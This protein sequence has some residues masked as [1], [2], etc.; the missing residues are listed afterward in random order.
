MPT[1]N[2][3]LFGIG[4]GSAQV[5]DTNGLLGQYQNMLAK[6]EQ[7]R[8]YE[9]KQLTDAQ[10]QLKPEG[11]RNDADRKDFFNQVDKWRNQAISA[12]QERDPYKKSLL[13]SQAQ[14]AYMQAQALADQSKK[15][16]VMENAFSTQLLNPAIRDRYNDDVVDRVL[17]NRELGVNDPTHIK[18]FNSLEQQADHNKFL[19]ANEEADKVL[20]DKAKFDQQL[21]KNKIGTSIQYFRKVPDDVRVET[22]KN[23]AKVDRNYKKSLMDI[24]PDIF[25]NPEMSY[26]QKIDEAVKRVVKT[27]GALTEY[28]TPQQKVDPQPDRFYEHYNYALAHPKGDQSAVIA[29]TPSNVTLPYNEGKAHVNASGYVPLSIPNKN[30]G[31]SAAYDLSSGKPVAQLQSSGDYSVVGVGNF[32]FIKKGN[33]KGA[34]A[35][36][37]FAENNPNAIQDK[38]MVH[39]QSTDKYGTTDYLISY[40]KLPANIKNSKSIREAL[41]NFVPASAQQPQSV[42]GKAKEL[43]KKAVSPKAPEKITYQGKTYGKDDIEQAAKASGMSVSEYLK[44][45]GQ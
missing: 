33:K 5:L 21:I 43:I 23:I 34:I 12:T 11:L 27:T 25:A 15:A 14:Q 10:A 20:I 30:F 38:P 35:Q 9:L 24:Y 32:P 44:E 31:G 3:S 42:M 45:L 2:A 22:Y 40:D 6:Q 18:D 41:V 26:D 19:K 13:Q 37:N 1:N 36:P 28:K 4:R 7:K 8:Q 17:K 16:A 29:G 39:V